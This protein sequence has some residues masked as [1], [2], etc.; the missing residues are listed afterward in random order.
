MSQ[1]IRPLGNSRLA[2]PALTIERV[3]VG[4]RGRTTL[5]NS[6]FVDAVESAAAGTVIVFNGDPGHEASLWGGLLAAAAVQLKLAG[7]VADGPVRDPGEIVELGCACFCTGS[8]SAGQAGILSLASIGEAVECGGVRVATGDFVFGDV[9]GVVVIPRGFE[10]E[11][12]EEAV[13]I[14]DRDQA[15]MRL[16]N[17]GRGLAET[18]KSLGRA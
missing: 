1:R 13:A 6:A 9:S 10:R 7:V 16:I 8:V 12:L 11:I 4:T 14:E 15:A 2:G 5:P 18:M 3:P 17:G